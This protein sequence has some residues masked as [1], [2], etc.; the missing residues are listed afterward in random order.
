[1]RSTRRVENGKGT[2]QDRFV[3]NG[4]RARRS[5]N[6]NVGDDEHGDEPPAEECLSS[7]SSAAVF[8]G[9]ASKGRNA[10]RGNNGAHVRSIRKDLFGARH[11]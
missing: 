8:G 5:V 10:S 1:L 7:C 3:D 2:S 6:V 9:K 4:E 11:Q